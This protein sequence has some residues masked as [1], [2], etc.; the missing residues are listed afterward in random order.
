M[1]NNWRAF[2]QVLFVIL[3][4]VLVMVAAGIMSQLLKK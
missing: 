1:H 2:L 3:L 4:V